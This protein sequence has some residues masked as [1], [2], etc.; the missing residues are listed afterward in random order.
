MFLNINLWVNGPLSVN[1]AIFPQ[2]ELMKTHTVFM[3]EV[4]RLLGRLFAEVLSLRQ[5]NK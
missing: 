5:I 2:K 3:F 4:Y 1:F